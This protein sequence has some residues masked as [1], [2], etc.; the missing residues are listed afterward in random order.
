MHISISR[1][2]ANE[3]EPWYIVSN[4]HPNQAI[5]KYKHVF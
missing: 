1:K 2:I 3:D 5:R 4:I